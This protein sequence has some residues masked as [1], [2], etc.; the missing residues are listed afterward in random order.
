MSLVKQLWLAIALVMLIAFGGSFLVSTLSARN[1]L[2]EQL[3]LKNFDNATSLAATLSQTLEQMPRDEVTIELQIASQFDLGHYESIR[4]VDPS[5]KALVELESDA[6]VDGA[7]EWFARLFRIEA[8]PGLAQVQNG[9]QPYGT[10]SVSS[11]A[12]FAYRELWNSMLR[13]L[14]WFLAAAVLTG[15]AGTVLLRLILRPLGAVVDQ[16]EAIGARRFITTAEPATREFRAVVRSMNA[17]ATR[18][19]QMLQ[20]ESS[21]LDQLRR[22]AHHD[23]V[24]GLL[25]RSHFLARVQSVLARE[26]AGAEGVLVIARL[27]DLHELN[28]EQGWAVMDTLIKRFAEALRAIAPKD[29]EWILGRLNGS[30]FAVLAPG[31]DDAGALAQRVQEA[32]QMLARELDLQAVCHLP[33]AATPYRHG[34]QLSRVLARVDVALA[35]AVAAGGDTVQV[36]GL[37]Q[38][39]PD[40]GKRMDL[41]TWRQ[42][43]DSALTMGQLKLHSY[44]VVDAGGQLLHG[45]CVARLRLDA[46]SDWLNAGEFVPWLARLGDLARLDEMVLDLAIARLLNCTDDLCIN[47]SAQ[48]M[49]DAVLVHRLASRLGETP[50]LAK[51]LWLEVPEYGVFQNLENFRILSALLKPLGCRIGIE[52]VGHQVA[53]I[54]ELHDLGLDYL[55]IDASFVHGI[56]QNQ[57][58]Q[59]FLR[60]LA[61]IGHSIGLS[62]MAEGVGS[63]AEFRALVE[64]GFDGA[65]GPAVTTRGG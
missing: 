38:A 40:A 51:R 41:V 54:G 16:A 25:N 39:L 49:N 52:H 35:N 33:A 2:E 36:A 43:F 37:E 50:E 31:E 42:R 18:V 8:E 5:G 30:D 45:E 24:T 7:P 13:L 48:S 56:D 12:S 22:E 4:L 64:L 28:R 26:D 55:K 1:Y 20:D 58:N 15:M 59:V 21:R 63:E 53:R 19:R 23:A 34:D 10:L 11:Q 6:G 60:G 62:A 3:R 65:T 27:L 46:E 32:L 9:W 29:A 57:A 17:L 14:G 47:F 44:P 61:M